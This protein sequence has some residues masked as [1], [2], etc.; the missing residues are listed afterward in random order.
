VTFPNDFSDLQKL[1]VDSGK[2][3]EEFWVVAPD[4]ISYFTKDSFSKMA[5][6]LGLSVELILADF[7]IDIFLLNDH[8]NYIKDKSKGKQAHYSRIYVM[9]LLFDIDFEHNL[10]AFLSFGQSGFGRNLTAFLRVNKVL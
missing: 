10:N 9:N 4:H 7:P 8:S 6:S 5:E 1:L 3:D 2:V